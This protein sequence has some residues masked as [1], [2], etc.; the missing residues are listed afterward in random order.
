MEDEE[1]LIHDAS[2]ALRIKGFLCSDELFRWWPSWKQN[3][4]E[5]GFQSVEGAKE[6]MLLRTR[7]D[8]KVLGKSVNVVQGEES[9]MGGGNSERS[10]RKP[11]T[12]CRN[13]GSSHWFMHDNRKP[14]SERLNDARSN[15][16]VHI[17]IPGSICI[18]L[19]CILLMTDRTG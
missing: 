15:R 19:T 13:D 17:N 16:L 1:M 12:A 18:I 5:S 4:E 11:G 9:C 3:N 7:T 10:E 2:G 8:G 6:E 14:G